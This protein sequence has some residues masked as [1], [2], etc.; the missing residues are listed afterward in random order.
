M[1]C[2]V[3]SFSRKVTKRC[4]RNFTEENWNNC[5]NNK[6]WRD[7]EDCN[8]VDEMVEIFTKNT[9]VALDEVAPYKSFTV[10]SNYRFGPSQETKS[11]MK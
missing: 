8:T 5:L 3:K 2:E 1:I 10:K 6:D 11:H 4:L 7:L 9:N